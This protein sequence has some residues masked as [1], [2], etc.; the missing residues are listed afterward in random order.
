MPRWGSIIAGAHVPGLDNSHL[1]II[2]AFAGGGLHASRDH[3]D[4]MRPGTAVLACRA[5]RELQQLHHIQ[6]HV[7]LV[8]SNPEYCRTLNRVSEPFRAADGHDRVDVQVLQRH[9]ADTVVDLFLE[10]EP[11]GCQFRSFWFIDPYGSG[12]YPRRALDPL[13]RASCGPE[14]IINFDTA[15]VR[16]QCG[17]G[18]PESIDPEHRRHLDALYGGDM[19]RGAFG[20]SID[21]EYALVNIYRHGF[22]G[23]RYGRP[24]RLRQ[25]EGQLR[26]FVHLAKV[27]RAETAF[28]RDY[29]AS[30]KF[31]LLAGRA[32][33]DS[34]RSRYA[35]RLFEAFRGETLDLAQMHA[36]QVLSLDRAQMMTVLRQAQ[37]DGFGTWDAGT[38]FMRWNAVR[39]LPDE[40][41]LTF[42]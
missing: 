16:R 28:R 11:H 31:G 19:W 25:S 41:L 13:D 5:A 23:F 32:L 2:D 27:Q 14:V 26:H 7:R 33:N 9:F 18:H 4:G 3:P 21:P 1:F 37:R 29:D 38:R 10:T 40:L 24:H 8:E 22:T 42:E 30:F 15:G 17:H 36:E 20:G 39:V 6:V 35:T 34:E 12:G